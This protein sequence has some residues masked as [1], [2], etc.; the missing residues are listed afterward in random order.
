MLHTRDELEG[1]WRAMVRVANGVLGNAAE[2]EDCAATAVVQVL[3]RQ[4]SDVDNLEAFL[5]TVAKR[6]A[7]DRLRAV[8]RARRRDA[9]LARQQDLTASDVA[10]DVVARAEARW[11]QA[12]A[13][14][15]LTTQSYRILEATANGAAISDIAAR[16]GLTVRAAQS[17]LFRSRRLL[18][19]V[20][21]RT[22]GALG[23]LATL[24]RRGAGH[25]GAAVATACIVLLGTA[26]LVQGGAPGVRPTT[27]YRLP[28]R[29]TTYDTE[30][31]AGE[32]QPASGVPLRP[33]A[34]T[35]HEQTRARARAPAVLLTEHDP[36]G[37]TTVTLEQHGDGQEEGPVAGVLRCVSHLSADPHHLGC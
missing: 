4:P 28:D 23:V 24:I 6:R 2:A 31:S 10:E 33:P 37:T 18:R 15:R 1:H 30:L 17:D 8:D 29:V 22:L 19:S 5:V 7:I 36:A 25:S 3:A 9:R 11:M 27:P 12:E 16:E 21:A 26:S 32:V 13:R 35:A 20:W 14:G 34:T